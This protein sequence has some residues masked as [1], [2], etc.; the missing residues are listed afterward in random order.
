MDILTIPVA[1]R[2]TRKPNKPSG[3]L[4]GFGVVAATS[5]DQASDEG[6]V[7]HFAAS[8]RVVHTLEEADTE[9]Q[10]VLQDAAVR[11]QPGAQQPT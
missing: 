11:A 1:R 5:S 2:S 6:T 10:L 7:Q 8:A 3:L 9:R 4:P